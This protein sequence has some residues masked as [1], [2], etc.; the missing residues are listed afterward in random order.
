MFK[1]IDFSAPFVHDTFIAIFSIP[2]ALN[3][4][5]GP[6][7]KEIP[8]SFILF[9]DFLFTLSTIGIFFLYSLYEEPY[10]PLLSANVLEH[11]KI[12][13][14]SLFLY[15]PLFLLTSHENIPSYSFLIILGLVF[16]SGLILPRVFYFAF[17][18]RK[19]NLLKKEHSDYLT[20]ITH[21]HQKNVKSSP[22]RTVLLVGLSSSL[23]PLLK[24]FS[25]NNCPYKLIGFLDDNPSLENFKFQNVPVLGGISDIASVI[26]TLK[27]HGIILDNVFV[28]DLDV[29]PHTLRFLLKSLENSKITLKRLI[30]SALTPLL[31]PN[32]I[33]H[34]F[35]PLAFEDLIEMIHP[36]LDSETLYQFIHNHRILITG[37]GGSLGTALVR[38][39][40]NLHPSHLSLLDHNE[41]SLLKL[42]TEISQKFPLL[43]RSYLLCDIT[44]KSRVIQLFTQEAP[45]YVFHLAAVK[46][47]SIAE[48]NPNQ[49]AL[50]NIIGTQNIAEAAKM[51]GA[52]LVALAS[53]SPCSHPYNI[54]DTTK[55]IA[56]IYFQSLDV[57]ESIHLNGP[58]F[59]VCRFDNLLGSSGS[60]ATIFKE[61]LS[62]K[63]P[64]TLTNPEAKRTFTPLNSAASLFLKACILGIR[65]AQEAG[66]IYEIRLSKPLKIL[67]LANY[68]CLLSGLSPGLNIELRIIGPRRG[69]L[70]KEAESQPF[71]T[72]QETSYQGLYKILTPLYE[73]PLIQRTLSE[74]EET[75]NHNR[76]LQ[77][78]RILHSLVPEFKRDSI[79]PGQSSK[80]G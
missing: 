14:L 31:E 24:I 26:T 78:L 51:S 48:I 44:D 69:E 38:K 39:I 49:T 5:Q 77:T 9:Q 35:R 27:N 64:I 3:L 72:H 80:T 4:S 66:H 20:S 7:F 37:A 54:L 50:T 65:P 18:E 12:A 34:A 73:L 71:Y 23:E 42:D 45:T 74:L 58:R 32:H 62:H 52:K 56:E 67:D 16:F 61:Q 1:Y 19:S 10:R 40:L 29:S 47:V 70:M 30:P 21:P 33:A 22:K 11:T 46:H 17:L 63:G 6:F 13:L 53:S 79:D 60:V 59:V 2:I 76:T 41:G 55:R 8:L 36:N 75:A 43:S 15:I 25:D 57:N 68:F 28:T